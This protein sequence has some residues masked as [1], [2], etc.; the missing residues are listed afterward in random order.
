[1]TK[2]IRNHLR[3]WRDYVRRMDRI[4]YQRTAFEY[5]RKGK[6]LRGIPRRR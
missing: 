5:I 4:I 2:E 1:M 6:R 3:R